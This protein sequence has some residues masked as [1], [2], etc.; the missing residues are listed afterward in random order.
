MKGLLFKPDML[1]A[2]REGRKTVTRRVI[3]PQ[4]QIVCLERTN[5]GSESIAGVFQEDVQPLTWRVTPHP[6]YR[7]GETVYVRELWATEK[8]YDGLKPSE[9]PH[10][11]K[12]FYLNDTKHN[13]GDTISPST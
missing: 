13:D 7:V 8:K 11:A 12:I 5:F 2:Y 10:D 9:L 4:P 1:R 3:N 6:R